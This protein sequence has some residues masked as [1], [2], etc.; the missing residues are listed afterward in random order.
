VHDF[1][2]LR[3]EL[4]LPLGRPIL[5]ALAERPPAEA[6]VLMRRLDVLEAELIEATG[7]ALGAAQL[8]EGLAERGCSAGV[9]TRNSLDN[10]LA[11]L[12]HCGIARHFA[13]GCVIGRDEAEPKPSP[14]GILR[15]L[16][17]WNADP[18][19]GVMVGDFRY[20]FDAGRAAGV[21]TAS[22]DATGQ[23]EWSALADL[24]VDSLDELLHVVS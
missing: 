18:T 13:D 8:L 9:L 23:H 20:D 22:V 19:S 10:A 15:L 17:G 4:G 12:E 3:R 11:T 6:A 14:D 2:A 1:D 7:P 24:C 16:R 21:V 5:E